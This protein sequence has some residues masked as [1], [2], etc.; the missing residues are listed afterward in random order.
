LYQYKRNVSLNFRYFFME[1]H[2]SKFKA[3]KNEAPTKP[4]GPKYEAGT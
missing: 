2:I 1:A 3:K 4:Q